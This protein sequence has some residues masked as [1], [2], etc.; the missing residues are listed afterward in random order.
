MKFSEA[1]YLMDGQD[2][3]HPAELYLETSIPLRDKKTREPLRYAVKRTMNTTSGT[4]PQI[5]HRPEIIAT[6]R[7]EYDD[8]DSPITGNETGV[9]DNIDSGTLADQA[10]HYID[11]AAQ[12]Y[13]A[14]LSSDR[15]Y[16]GLVK[17]NPGGAI[18]Q[19]TWSVNS[20]GMT[21]RASRNTEH[22]PLVPEYK[23][24][25]RK[26]Q[27]AGGAEDATRQLRIAVSESPTL[28]HQSGR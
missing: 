18:Q 14:D 8:A 25:R 28:S 13:M 27:A 1:V 15:T 26:E 9:V 4:Q 23:A 22:N 16:A 12:E 20:G 2:K 6:V 21:T 3:S 24:R 11:A 17:I 7:A 5:V 10:N 19:V